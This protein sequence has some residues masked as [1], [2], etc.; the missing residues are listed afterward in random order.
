MRTIWK[1]Q[2]QTK[3]VQEIEVPKE[4]Q[5][6]TA[7]LQGDALCVWYRCDPTAEKEKRWIAICGTGHECPPDWHYLST[8]QL[9]GGG[10]IF[11]VFVKP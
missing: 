4:S 2:L 11:H 7:Q 10:L 1:T 3:D 6:L 9:Y 5:F 8:F